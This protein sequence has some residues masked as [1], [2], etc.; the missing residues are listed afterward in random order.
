MIILRKYQKQLLQEK[1]ILVSSDRLFINLPEYFF[2]L[3]ID[4]N[5]RIV[6]DY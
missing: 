1:K 2:I 6:Y 4:N 5:K 3:K